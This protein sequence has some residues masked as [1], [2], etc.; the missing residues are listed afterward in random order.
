M[1]SSM[2]ML[3]QKIHIQ[4]QLGCQLVPLG[5]NETCS[6]DEGTSLPSP[7]DPEMI[8]NSFQQQEHILSNLAKKAFKTE[9]FMKL[10]T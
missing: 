3:Y 7:K 1:L 2:S 6:C 4:C 5:K 9:I 8:I 10:D